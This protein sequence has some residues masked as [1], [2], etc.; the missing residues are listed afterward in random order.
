[1]VAVAKKLDV[2]ENAFCLSIMWLEKDYNDEVFVLD[3]DEESG[4]LQLYGPIELCQEF[5]ERIKLM[6]E[7]ACTRT[8]ES[9]P[10]KLIDLS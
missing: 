1:M 7:H 5:N 4:R 3:A 2:F 8:L 6:V 10:S 9:D